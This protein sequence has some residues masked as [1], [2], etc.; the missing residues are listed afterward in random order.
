[1]ATEG[2]VA[3]L[4]FSPSEVG[5]AYVPVIVTE[6]GVAIVVWPLGRSI[7]SKPVISSRRGV[8][9]VPI[10]PSE[11]MTLPVSLFRGDVASV[12]FRQK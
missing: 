7:P 12:L 2:G 3:T 4:S 11:A 6:G 9:S 5:M 10:S 1:M 8:A